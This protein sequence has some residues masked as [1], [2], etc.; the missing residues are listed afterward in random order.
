MDAEP[1][2]A[3]SLSV[4]VAAV[5]LSTVEDK[6]LESG[7]IAMPIAR[8]AA[9]LALSSMPA[10]QIK[11]PAPISVTA[12]SV[13]KENRTEAPATV[14][15]QKSVV[16]VAITN[17]VLPAALAPPIALQNKVPAPS[18]ASA[19]TTALVSSSYYNNIFY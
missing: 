8:G 14:V 1:M 7:A 12:P 6:N 18:Q 10:S 2:T 4:K 17:T 15:K 16:A 19:T 13:Q 11:A 9:V 3:V 5:E